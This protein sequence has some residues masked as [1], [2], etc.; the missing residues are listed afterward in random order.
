V[1]RVG[2]FLRLICHQLASGDFRVIALAHVRIV[3]N[4]TGPAQGLMSTTGRKKYKMEKQNCLSDEVFSPASSTESSRRALLKGIDVT[5][6][7]DTP[8]Q[9]DPR[10]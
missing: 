4:V 3:Q 2:S 1:G 10:K 6:V 9:P 5:A 8:G 7:E